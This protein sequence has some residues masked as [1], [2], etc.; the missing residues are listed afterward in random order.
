MI[1]NLAAVCDALR[2]AKRVAVLTG[3]GMSAAS[4]LPTY[5]GIGGLYNDIEVEQGMPIEEILHAYTMVRNPALTWKYLLQIAR[6]CNAAK[7]NAG[8]V[9]L[10]AWQ[11]RFELHVITQNVDGFHREAGSKR[12]IELHGNLSELFCLDCARP[13]KLSDFDFNALPPRCVS[14]DGLVRPNVV[15][16]GEVLPAAGMQAYEA[17]LARGF[18]VMLAIGTSAGF[19]YIQEPLRLA[20]QQGAITVEINPD[21][22]SLSAEVS[23]KIALPAVEALEAIE[24]SLGAVDTI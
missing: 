14:C 4:G 22:T 1:A 20:R 3:A 12:L 24:R 6:A 8:H 10:A 16:F 7:P 5:R 2:N 23:L 17:E 18:D 11:R 9:I 15:L 13:F 19:P 21:T